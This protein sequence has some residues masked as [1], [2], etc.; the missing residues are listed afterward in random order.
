MKVTVG[1]SL[2]LDCPV[3]QLSERP[4]QV[5]LWKKVRFDPDLDDDHDHHGDHDDHDDHGDHGDHDNNGDDNIGDLDDDDHD[6]HLH[7]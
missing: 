2:H 5:M 3:S 7:F 4:G 1:S 6:C